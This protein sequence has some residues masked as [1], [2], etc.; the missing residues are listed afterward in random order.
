MNKNEEN[1][2][3][4]M[5]MRRTTISPNKTRG[6]K[7]IISEKCKNITRCKMKGVI[8]PNVTEDTTSAVSVLA[9]VITQTTITLVLVRLV[10]DK[11]EDSAGTAMEP[12]RNIQTDPEC[13]Q[14][15]RRAR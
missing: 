14:F 3:L 6:I 9:V 10:E 8:T 12:K 1:G 5:L 13:H 11:D 15:L 2:K 7:K 4:G